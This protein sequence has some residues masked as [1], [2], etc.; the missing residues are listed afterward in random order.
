MIFALFILLLLLKQCLYF[1]DMVFYIGERPPN[2]T[3]ASWTF[4][5]REAREHVRNP[6]W[7]QQQR[8]ASQTHLGPRSKFGSG[9]AR[10]FAQ[11]FVSL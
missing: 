9:G 10:S 11:K 3:A 7:N 5:V 6:S 2:C 1:N 8:K 4:F